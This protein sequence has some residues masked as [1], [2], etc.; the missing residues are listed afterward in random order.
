MREI[1]VGIIDTMQI[2]ALRAEPTYVRINSND[3]YVMSV[4]RAGGI[5][6]ILPVVSDLQSIKKQVESMDAIVLSGGYDINPLI[7]GEEPA[8]GLGT[9][10][11]ERDD[12]D[13]NVAKF[14]LEMNKPLLGVCRGLQVLN[15]ASGGTLIQDISAIKENLKHLQSAK[16]DLA[17]HTIDIETETNLHR[18]I[19]KSAGVNSFHHQA[20]KKIAPGYLVSARSKDGIVEAIEKEDGFAVGVQWH[21]EIMAVS[22]DAMLG[23]FRALILQCT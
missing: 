10:C 20:A 23:L 1:K 11:P 14:S 18:I 12:Y 7:Y 15:V 9:I 19:G 8:T 3:N 6:Y 13:I 16:P 5:P 4:S 17:T 21:P 2:I 22:D